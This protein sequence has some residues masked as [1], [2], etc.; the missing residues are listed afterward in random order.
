[1][2]SMNAQET[3]VLAILNVRWYG[4]DHVGRVNHTA[5]H[6]AKLFVVLL[7]VVHEMRLEPSGHIREAAIV[8]TV[9]NEQC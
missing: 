4:A 9:R 3:A 7:K 6:R 5:V 2:N 8:E 1:M